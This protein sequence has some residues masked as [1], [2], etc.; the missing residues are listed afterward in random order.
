MAARSEALQRGEEQQQRLQEALDRQRVEAQALAKQTGELQ[1]DRQRLVS[2][3]VCLSVC[4]SA[5]LPHPYCI[6][7]THGCCC[8]CCADY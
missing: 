3:C 4:L 8:C 2:A 5:S 6:H 7:F 1:A